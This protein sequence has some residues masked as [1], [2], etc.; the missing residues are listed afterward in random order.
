MK[1][2]AVVWQLA[3]QILV[4]V[5]ASKRPLLYHDPTS[6]KGGVVLK[7]LSMLAPPFQLNWLVWLGQEHSH[8]SA[9]GAAVALAVTVGSC[10][11]AEASDPDQ[12]QERTEG[13]ASGENR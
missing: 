11:R 1:V 2:L 4:G 3:R 13:P 5:G 7:G 12:T 9:C 8:V 10:G 6:R